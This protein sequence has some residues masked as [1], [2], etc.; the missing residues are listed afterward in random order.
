M[1]EAVEKE[2]AQ[3]V[4]LADRDGRKDVF[5]ALGRVLLELRDKQIRDKLKR[6][7]MAIHDARGEVVQKDQDLAL[8][9]LSLVNRGLIL[10]GEKVPDDPSETI[11]SALIED[12]RDKTELE[13]A[14]ASEEAELEEGV[15]KKLDQVRI[16]AEARAD[17]LDETLSHVSRDQEDVRNR[18]RFVGDRIEVFPRYAFLRTGLTALRQRRILGL[19]KKAR[20]Q[21]E[22][23][24][25]SSVDGPGQGGEGRA[26]DATVTR[27][28][29]RLTRAV[30][31]VLAW[32][33]TAHDLIN[34]GRFDRFVTDV[35]NHVRET[36]GD[37]RVYVQ[38]RER[39][40]KLWLERKGTG[41]RDPFDRPYLLREGNLEA[42]VEAGRNLEWALVLQAAAAREARLLAAI[43]SMKDPGEIVT[44][45]AANMT[46]KARKQNTEIAAL[47]R[48]FHEGV[49]GSVRDPEDPERY[50]ERVRP[51]L[52]KK[53][54]KPLR[55]EAFAAWAKPFE[56]KR[57]QELA[58][59]QDGL[60]RDLS[61]ALVT[62]YDLFEAR[63]PAKPPTFDPFKEDRGVVEAGEGLFIQYRDETPAALADRIEQE[64]EWLDSRTGDP[65][66]RKR[67]IAT[68]RG[69]DTFDVRYARLQSAYFQ[70]V[71]Q[72]FQARAA[73]RT[74]VEESPKE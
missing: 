14:I 22:A 46:D 2:L 58:T 23:F 24:G 68:L 7:A 54:L 17:T 55:G 25:R 57:Y 30:D 12:P 16:V 44:A 34:G 33:G 35:Q 60:R 5:N 8:Q 9:V 11:F 56:A 20:G 29:A 59:A 72:E 45:V 42:M 70:A 48:G 47:I 62:L 65:E 71:A 15:Y 49:S 32:A 13:E 28:C 52:E 63:V 27:A 26:P 31:G 51:E 64:G 19:L 69:L 73:R 18:T 67:L 1:E 61:D 66:V 36:A 10:A 37:L 74:N 4:Y 50:N 6:A 38:A 53:L 21:A 43:R 41:F 40:H 39:L 3:L